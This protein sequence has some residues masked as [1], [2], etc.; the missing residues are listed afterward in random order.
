MWI[1]GMKWLQRVIVG[2]VALVT[3]GVIPPTHDIWSTLLT[4]LDALK[5][6]KQDEGR[7]VEQPEYSVQLQEEIPSKEESFQRL[8]TA[9]YEQ[10]II[11]FGQKVG[12]VIQPIFDKEIYPALERIMTEYYKDYSEEELADLVVTDRPAGKYSERIFHVYHTK[13]NEESFY[14]HVRTENRP[15]DGY[16]YNFHYHLASDQFQNHYDIADIF[17]SK[18]QPPKWMS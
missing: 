17:W 14:F 15:K 13:T 6:E 2:F 9:A 4:D 11:K 1:R 10:S 16:Y 3:L 18:N 5:K 12:P 8:F 7:V